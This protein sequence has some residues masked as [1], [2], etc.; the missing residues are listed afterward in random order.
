MCEC[1][2]ENRLRLFRAKTAVP[3]YCLWADG[4]AILFSHTV[5]DNSR[6]QAFTDQC[7]SY[8]NKCCVLNC[9]GNRE[10]TVTKNTFVP[11]DT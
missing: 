1:A 6:A 4:E 5:K 2:A 10:A 8:K 7:K 11:T 9:D 3:V